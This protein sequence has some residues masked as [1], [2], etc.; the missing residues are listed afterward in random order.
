MRATSDGSH[1]IVIEPEN[2]DD[3]KVMQ[4]IIEQNGK[5][6]AIVYWGDVT[7]EGHELIAFVINGTPI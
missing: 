2:D 1:R 5:D 4:N 6:E 7:I 3:R